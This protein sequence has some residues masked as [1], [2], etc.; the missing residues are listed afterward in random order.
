MSKTLKHGKSA[1]IIGICKYKINGRASMLNG[2]AAYGRAKRLCNG[3]ELV[4]TNG[5][6]VA[7]FERMNTPCLFIEVALLEEL[8]PRDPSLKSRLSS[9]FTNDHVFPEVD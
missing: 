6:R 9:L 4:V 3:M 1:P 7:I 2:I 5:T 8:S